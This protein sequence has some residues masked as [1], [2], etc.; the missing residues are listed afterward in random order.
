M[1][2]VVKEAQCRGCKSRGQDESTEFNRVK[3]MEQALSVRE[4]ARQVGR[5][6]VSI[7]IVFRLYAKTLLFWS[8]RC[9][10][11]HHKNFTTK[12]FHQGSKSP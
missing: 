12:V 8:I 7:S 10:N 4:T 5:E 9:K 6:Q 2:K 1:K 11:T 3:K